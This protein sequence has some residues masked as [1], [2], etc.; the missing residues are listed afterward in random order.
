LGPVAAQLQNKRLLIIADGALQYIPFQALPLPDTGA[1]PLVVKHE[2][3][4][5]PSASVLQMLRRAAMPNEAGSRRVAVLADPVFDRDDAR[6]RLLPARQSPGTPPS[7]ATSDLDSSTENLT[8]SAAD[9]GLARLT[10]LS[11]SR[12]EADAILA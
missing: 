2:I 11:F 8:R 12:R 4:S 5:L 10:R 6:V 3:V 9:T 1:T 7:Q